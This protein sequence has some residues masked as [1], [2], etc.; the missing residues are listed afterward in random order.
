MQ[1][2]QFY[3]MIF[4]QSYKTWNHFAIRQW[5]LLPSNLLLERI[6]FYSIAH[7]R[8][9]L[10][11]HLVYSKQQFL[12]IVQFSWNLYRNK[13]Y[14]HSPIEGQICRS[15]NIIQVLMVQM[16]AQLKEHEFISIQQYFQQVMDC[17]LFSWIIHLSFIK[18]Q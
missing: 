8:F 6:V 17:L 4:L 16:H 9:L 7:E 11:L 14:F 15:E 3:Q 18:L 2:F 13:E 12:R 5:Y 1:D 10:N